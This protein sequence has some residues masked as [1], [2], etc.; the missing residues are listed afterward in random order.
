MALNIAWGIW[1]ALNLWVSCTPIAYLWDPSIPGGHCLDHIPVFISIGV[2]DIVVDAC[3]FL[4]P[5]PMVWNLQLPLRNKLELSF[6]FGTS[7]M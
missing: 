3:I 6:L 1:A 2:I 7:I 5:I 4:L